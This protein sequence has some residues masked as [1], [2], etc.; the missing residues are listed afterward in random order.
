MRR[1]RGQV[2]V[3]GA[4]TEMNTKTLHGVNETEGKGCCASASDM[5]QMMLRQRAVIQRLR[6]ARCGEETVKAGC[7]SKAEGGELWLR[8]WLRV[9]CCGSE[10]ENGVL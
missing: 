5:M 1:R 2:R 8:G 9:V 6:D 4:F 10:A 3:V 7:G